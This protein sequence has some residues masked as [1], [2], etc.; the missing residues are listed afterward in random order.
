MELVIFLQRDECSIATTIIRQ[1]TS[2]EMEEHSKL[3]ISPWGVKQ[4]PII[5]TAKMC[6]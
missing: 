1:I 2:E 6:F 4:T 3:A 5:F